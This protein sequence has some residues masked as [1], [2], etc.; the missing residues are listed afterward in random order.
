MRRTVQVVA[1]AAVLGGCTSVKLVQRDGCWI[2]QTS[3]AFGRVVEDI[4][5]C[6]SPQPEWSDDRL[7]RV[8]QECIA[9]A[10]HRW[11]TRALMAW[12]QGQ[13]IPERASD[14]D[15]MQ[16]CMNETSRALTTDN[17][18]LRQQNELLSTRVQEVGHERDALRTRAE[19]ASAKLL[20]TNEKM[21]ERLLGDQEKLG[22]RL[23]G[24]QDRMAGYLG[25][26][27]KKASQPAV[28]TATANSKSDGAVTADSSNGA[29]AV[30][31][32]T[33]TAA[34]RP[35]TSLRSAQGDRGG[36]RARRAPK[37]AAAQPST[38]TSCPP[39][40]VTSTEGD[41]GAAQPR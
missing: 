32:T 30:P 11:Q 21:A 25:E 3:K 39:P 12:N 19:D 20:S 26:A 31:A 22:D 7:T 41:G 33:T 27:A 38:C 18:R 40:K 9:R 36:A 6:S 28:A 37:P 2:R 35:S 1:L 5:P 15:V 16:D 4:G 24:A 10:E 13:G 29:S 17:D 8:V 14:T 23:I 34:T